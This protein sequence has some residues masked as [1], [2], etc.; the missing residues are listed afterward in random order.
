MYYKQNDFYYYYYV[1][2]NKMQSY[3]LRFKS[4]STIT[5]SGPSQSGKTTLVEEIVRDRDI[6]FTEPIKSVI[7]YSAFHPVQKIP[8]VTYV[9]GIPNDFKDRVEPHC[10]VVIDDYMSELAN[11][12]ELTTLM[13][14]A[15]HHLPLTLIY[16]TQNI[17][18]KGSDNKTR[19]L[20]TN[21][22]ILFKNPQDKGQVDYIG[23][24]MYPRDKGFLSS[25]YNDVTSKHPYSYI[26]IDS[27]QTT[28]DYL[29]IRTGVTKGRILRIFVPHSINL[30]E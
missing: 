19:R 1:L 26:L 3:D 5:V 22:L 14:K 4:G 7:W 28:P 21:Y 9:I 30:T 20:N 16:I 25:V 10:L 11:S 15:V 8:G 13:T 17:F 6:M 24:Q 2:K 29:R 12:T 27:H 18:H 23:H